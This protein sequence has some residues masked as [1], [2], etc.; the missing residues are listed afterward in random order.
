MNSLTLKE[1]GFAEFLPLKDLSFVNVPC[2]K[3]GVIVLSNLKPEPETSD[4]LYIGRSKKLTRRVFG[5][6]LAGCGGKITR[7]ISAKLLDEGFLEKTAISWMLTDDPKMAQQTLLD[8]FKK[9]HGAFPAWNVLKKVSVKPKAPV[10]EAKPKPRSA[11]KPAK[12]RR[13]S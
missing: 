7:K 1:N 11:R 8:A 9:E 5:G 4:I 2:N 12:G 13:S 6:Y 3:S 10:A